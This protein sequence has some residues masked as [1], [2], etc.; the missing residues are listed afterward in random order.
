M[1]SSFALVKDV[2]CDSPDI[3]QNFD[4]ASYMGLWYEYVKDGTFRSEIGGECT[5]AYY[6]LQ[7]G[8]VAVYN[9][10]VIDGSRTSAQGIAKCE[11]SDASCEVSFGGAFSPYDVVSTDYT[12]YTLIYSCLPL[13][14]NKSDSFIWFLTRDEIISDELQ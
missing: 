3:V 12:S 13:P 4:I 9:S 5:T 8:N 11:G 14:E 7:D 1:G 2:P 6:S 10:Q